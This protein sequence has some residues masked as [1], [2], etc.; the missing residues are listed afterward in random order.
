LGYL[1]LFI[2]ED[3]EFLIKASVFSDLIRTP[4]SLEKCQYLVF[5]TAFDNRMERMQES[6]MA[7]AE[8]FIE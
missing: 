2:V 5:S 8:V 3:A 7:N 4:E 1:K 6:F